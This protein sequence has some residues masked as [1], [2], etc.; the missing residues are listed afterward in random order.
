VVLLG[1]DERTAAV[2]SDGAWRALGAGGVTVVRGDAR[3][4]AE[5]GAPIAGLPEPG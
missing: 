3:T 2:W 5:A 4:R 1:L